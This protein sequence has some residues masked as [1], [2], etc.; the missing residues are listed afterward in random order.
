MRGALNSGTQLEASTL[1]DILFLKYDQQNTSLF[2][3]RI[4]LVLLWL[5]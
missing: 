2:F 4:S 1:I 5:L 3:T